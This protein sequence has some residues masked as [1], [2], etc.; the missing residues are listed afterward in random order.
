M[1]LSQRRDCVACDNEVIRERHAH[2]LQRSLHLAGRRDISAAGLRVSAR[3]IVRH[4][5]CRSV[6]RQC[7]FNNFA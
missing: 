5:D 1:P 6:V 4:D 7:R 3:M 2:Q